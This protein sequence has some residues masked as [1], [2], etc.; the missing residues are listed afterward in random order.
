MHLDRS[1]RLFQRRTHI[2]GP[3]NGATPSLELCICH[4]EQSQA[5]LPPLSGLR[6]CFG[7]VRFPSRFCS[8]PSSRSRNTRYNHSP[9]SATRKVCRLPLA[10][11]PLPHQRP[12]QQFRDW[13]RTATIRVLQTSALVTGWPTHVTSYTRGYPPFLLVQNIQP[14]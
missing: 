5:W 12:H 6:A 9:P 3:M 1:C 7:C 14:L 4:H 2:E 11:I 8:I 13:W 10:Q